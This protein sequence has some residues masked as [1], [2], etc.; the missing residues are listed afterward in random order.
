MSNPGTYKNM[1][2]GLFTGEPLEYVGAQRCRTTEAMKELCGMDVDGVGPGPAMLMELMCKEITGSLDAMGHGFGE[3]VREQV[4]W[5]HDFAAAARRKA[6]KDRIN[7]PPKVANQALSKA[8]DIA[9]SALEKKWAP[10]KT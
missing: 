10:A 1:T 3:S 7:D 4:R 8:A 9:K 2:G 5:C 6:E